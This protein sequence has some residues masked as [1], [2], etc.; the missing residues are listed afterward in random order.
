MAKGE[1]TRARTQKLIENDQVEFTAGVNGYHAQRCARVLREHLPG[2]EVR[3][4]LDD[5]GQNLIARA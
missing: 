3:V 4:M 5:G 1:N 2:N